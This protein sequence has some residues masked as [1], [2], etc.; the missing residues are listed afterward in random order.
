MGIWM[1]ECGVDDGACGRGG[2]GREK[3][4]SAAREGT[5]RGG[6]PTSTTQTGHNQPRLTVR[7]RLGGYH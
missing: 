3:G 2:K 6:G 7:S 1:W 4:T 5:Q